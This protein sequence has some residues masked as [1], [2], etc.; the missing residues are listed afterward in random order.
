MSAQIC[1]AVGNRTKDKNGE[2][3]SH[4]NLKCNMYISADF[5]TC[6]FGEATAA[7]EITTTINAKIRKAW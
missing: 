3:E 1:A 5:M 6:S 2:K 4:K 7:C